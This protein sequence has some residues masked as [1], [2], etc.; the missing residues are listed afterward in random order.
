MNIQ[1]SPLSGDT[2]CS[3][4]V[5]LLKASTGTWTTAQEKTELRA[6]ALKVFAKVEYDFGPEDASAMLH[7]ANEKTLLGEA[8]LSNF[9]STVK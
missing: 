1:L 2:K 5:D 6:E 9:I 4:A 3:I 8:F 7:G